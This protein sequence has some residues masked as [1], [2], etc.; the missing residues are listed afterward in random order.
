MIIKLGQAQHA[1]AAGPDRPPRPCLAAR[2]QQSSS[3]TWTG[4]IRRIV[5]QQGRSRADL[6]DQVSGSGCDRSIAS[7]SA[8][9]ILAAATAVSGV[10]TIGATATSLSRA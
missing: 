2:P 1:R 9:A 8:S 4:Q 5:H 10:P 6:L 3:P 7:A